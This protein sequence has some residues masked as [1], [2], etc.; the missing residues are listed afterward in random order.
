MVVLPPT[1]AQDHKNLGREKLNT[2]GMGAYTF[3]SSSNKMN[4]LS[5]TFVD[6]I[7][8]YLFGQGIKYQRMFY[9]GLILTIRVKF[10]RN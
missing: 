1:A 2:G 6:P 9:A 4:E 8:Q 3:P 5:K 10:T 7:V